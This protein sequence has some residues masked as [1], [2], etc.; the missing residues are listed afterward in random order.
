MQYR[1]ISLG[2]VCR[3]KWQN[4]WERENVCAQLRPSTWEENDRIVI[5]AKPV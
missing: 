5:S 2:R 1:N 3:G 4:W